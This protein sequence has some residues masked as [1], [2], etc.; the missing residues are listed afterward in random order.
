[1][2]FRTK[3]NQSTK[4][5]VKTHRHLNSFKLFNFSITFVENLYYAINSSIS[6]YHKMGDFIFWIMTFLRNDDPSKNRLILDI[7]IAI[8]LEYFGNKSTF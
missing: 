1:M 6:Q 3:E 7:F 5:G 2:I 8:S 4:Q